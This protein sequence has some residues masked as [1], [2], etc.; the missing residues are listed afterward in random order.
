[1]RGD[2]MEQN[3][4]RAEAIIDAYGCEQSNLIAIM[5]EIQGEYKYLSEGALTLIAEKLGISTAKV[6]SVATFT[7]TSRWRQRDGT[8]SRCAPARPAMCA[9]PGPSMTRCGT[10]WV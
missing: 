7:R 9:N 10:H 5:Q 1:M 2:F 3:L 8:S 4:E 6:Y